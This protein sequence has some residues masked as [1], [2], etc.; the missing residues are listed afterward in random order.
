MKSMMNIKLWNSIKIISCMVLLSIVL[1]SCGTDKS[2]QQDETN[3]EYSIPVKIKNLKYEKF[4][5]FIQVTGYVEALYDAYISPEMNGQIKK[6]YVKEG[7]YVQTGQLLA[8]LNTE[9]ISKSI[10]ELKTGLELAKT[11][12]NKQKE[13]WDQGIGSEVQYLQAKNQKE[14]LEK[15]LETLYAQMDMAKIK[16]PF[17]GYI[18]SVM[19]KEGELAVPGMQ[20]MQLVNFNKLKIVADVSEKYLNSIHKGDTVKITFPAYPDIELYKTIYRTG[21]VIKQGNRTFEIEIQLDN[22]KD[23]ILKPNIIATVYINDYSN[24]KALTVPSVIIKK[25]LKGDFLYVVNKTD[26]LFTA[27]KRHV[28]IG[29]S[30]DNMTEIIE[31]LKEGEKVVIA[32]YNQLS[33]GAVVNIK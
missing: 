21:N 16:A 20:L 7:D 24:N 14:S 18:E 33:N 23:N 3:M 9:V 12:Y 29:V 27:E 28:K 8:E 10:E 4:H 2:D 11:L 26:S 19:Q 30:Q 22:L 17:S 5:H 6:I 31:G 15:K 13:L 25:D 1:I 32:G